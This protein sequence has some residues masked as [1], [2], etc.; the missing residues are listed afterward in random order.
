MRQKVNGRAG[1]GAREGTDNG[2]QKEGRNIRARNSETKSDYP[3]VVN[4]ESNYK[5]DKCS[6]LKIAIDR[7]Q[8]HTK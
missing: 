4:R 5:A 1:G 8:N 7:V 3:I 6:Y 2:E